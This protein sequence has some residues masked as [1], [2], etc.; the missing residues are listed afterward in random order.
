VQTLLGHLQL[1]ASLA[2]E[3][4]ALVRVEPNALS[5]L[6]RMLLTSLTVEGV[7][8]FQAKAVGG[9]R[10][11]A[12]PG[13]PCLAGA[14]APRAARR[15]SAACVQA[16]PLQLQPRSCSR[17]ASRCRHSVPPLALTIP[18]VPL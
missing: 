18:L 17:Q 12:W 13:P 1:M 6:V 10:S 2:A 16:L 9:W 14:G 15:R 11:C 5:P 7:Q 8:D 3:L 4:M